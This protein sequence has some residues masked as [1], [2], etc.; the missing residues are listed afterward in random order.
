MNNDYLR[1]NNSEL[2]TDKSVNIYSAKF[3][4]AN[5]TQATSS[6]SAI[7][8]I[9]DEIYSLGDTT[10]FISKDIVE[11]PK[12]LGTIIFSFVFL[13]VIM[14]ITFVCNLV[15]DL[16]L[17]FLLSVLLAFFVPISLLYFFYKLDARGKLKFSS[18]V[19]Y[20]MLGGAFIVGVEFVFNS[21]VVTVIR[22]YF[23]VTALRCLVELLGVVLISV[24]LIRSKYNRARTTSI[25]I[26]CA[27]SAGFVIVKSLYSNFLSML[28]EVDV[29]TNLGFFEYGMRLG[30]ILNQDGFIGLS[31]NRLLNSSSSSCFLLP[32]TF[33][34]V[35]IIFIDVL[36]TED[37]S[38][39]KKAI[40]SIFAFIFCATSYIL[41]SIQTS[42]NVLSVLYKALSIAFVLYLFARTINN[43]IKSEKYE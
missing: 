42:F 18:L 10:E 15:K 19:Y 25:L 13:L 43:C 22:D 26:T 7:S 12:V 17:V 34:F 38:I 1:L 23:T 2:K 20:A 27:V 5:K 39:T 31:L 30:A 4:K 29:E 37:W 16:M 11:K 32:I 28:V 24:L 3:T 9:V 40:S 41:I 36:E 6:K 8:L 21:S 14:A 33:I 35:A